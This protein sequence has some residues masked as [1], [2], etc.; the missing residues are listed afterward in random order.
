MSSR[1]SGVNGR[2][3]EGFARR[4][5]GAIRQRESVFEPDAE[6]S[7][8]PTYADQRLQAGHP[9]FCSSTA[10]SLTPDIFQT[11]WVV[12]TGSEVMRSI[13]RSHARENPN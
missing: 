5:N 2:W 8:E 1:S 11:T 3:D 7:G 13:A 12:G 6:R 4:Y 9:G 10:T